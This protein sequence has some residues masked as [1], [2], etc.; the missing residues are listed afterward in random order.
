MRRLLG[1][2][3]FW[4]CSHSHATVYMYARKVWPPNWMLSRYNYYY[5]WSKVMLYCNSFAFWQRYF[6]SKRRRVVLFKSKLWELD[7]SPVV[8]PVMQV[9][10][11]LYT[12]IYH[13][14]LFLILRQR[15]LWEE[16]CFTKTINDIHCINIS[17]S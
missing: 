10:Y 16:L 12:Y 14:N 17:K 2:Y 6:Q 8:L 7:C 3:V 9:I 11:Y 4:T 13:I 15:W 5:V 1:V